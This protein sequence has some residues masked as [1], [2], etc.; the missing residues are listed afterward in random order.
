MFENPRRGKQARNFKTNVPKI[1]DLKSSSEQIFSENCR[2]VSLTIN[3]S[4]RRFPRISSRPSINRLRRIIAPP[5]LPSSVSFTPYLSGWVRSSK[6]DQWEFKLCSR[7]YWHWKFI[8]EPNME[9][10][11]SPR[12]VFFYLIIFWFNGIIKQNVWGTT[13]S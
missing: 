12:S 9:H 8:K 6:A 3:R 13:L 10:F 1:L 4:Y 11:I 2:W 5:L 7:G